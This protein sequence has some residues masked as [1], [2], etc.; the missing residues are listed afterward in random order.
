MEPDLSCCLEAL[1]RA[2]A[3]AVLAD[4]GDLRFLLKQE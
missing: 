4:L 2:L 3:V 1:R